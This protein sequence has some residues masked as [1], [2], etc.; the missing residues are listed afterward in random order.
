MGRARYQPTRWTRRLQLLVTGC[1]VVFTIGTALQ[2]WI[3]VDL[4][5]MEHAMRLAGQSASEAAASAPGFLSGLRLVGTAYVLGNAVGLLALWGRAWVFWVVLAVNLTQGIGWFIT[6]PP[7]VL[8]AQGATPGARALVTTV[9]VDGGA[10]LLTVVLV[11]SLV[12]FRG[13][14]ARRKETAPPVPSA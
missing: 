7:V 11:A 1:A 6:M 2:N 9:V 10:L 5:M 4:T 12:A 13:P 14:W 8:E 3:F